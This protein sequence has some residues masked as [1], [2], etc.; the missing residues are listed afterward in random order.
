MAKTLAVAFAA[1][2][3][4]APLAPADAGVLY[5]LSGVVGDS[6]WNLH[7][8]FVGTYELSKD[9]SG[10]FQFR[11][12]PGGLISIDY[13]GPPI[14]LGLNQE[15]YAYSS[16]TATCINPSGCYASCGFGCDLPGYAY[17]AFIADSRLNCCLGAPIDGPIVIDSSWYVQDLV[18]PP[19]AP[20]GASF[21]GYMEGYDYFLFDALVDPDTLGQPFSLTVTTVADNAVPEP[22]SIADFAAAM[23]MLGTLYFIRRRKCRAGLTSSPP[24]ARRDRPLPIDRRSVAASPC[25]PPAS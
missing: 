22:A 24:A 5:S 15:L 9:L 17:D 16:L 19:F 10:L 21:M 14:V 4:T 18:T 1:L 11:G 25:R 13:S 12:G 20:Y 8:E 2:L 23:M 6:N 3:M 7:P